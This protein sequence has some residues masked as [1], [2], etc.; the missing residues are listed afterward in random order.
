[1]LPAI[2][3]NNSF[4][5]NFLLILFCAAFI[6]IAA[7]LS[8]ELA[9]EK[10]EIGIVLAI[11]KESYSNIVLSADFLSDIERPLLFEITLNN[12]YPKESIC[13]SSVQDR[14]PPEIN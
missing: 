13:K 2:F 7:D 3:R 10:D 1:M 4:S 12:L 14:G 11:F 6:I 9:A 5:N 8:S